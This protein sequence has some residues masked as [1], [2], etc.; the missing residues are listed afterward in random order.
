MNMIITYQVT[1]RVASRASASVGGLQVQ[2]VDKAVGG[3]AELAQATTDD[4]GVYTA[5]FSVDAVR[6]RGK[7]NPDLQ[8][9]VLADRTLLGASE[10]RYNA[11]P[12]ETLN[13]F[14][15]DAATSALRSEHEALILALGGQFKGRLRDLKESD[16]QQ[17]VT[18][19]ANKTGWDARVVAL[20]ALA[21]QFSAMTGGAAGG[22][23]AAAV[24][25]PADAAGAADAVNAAPIPPQFF[26]ALFRAGLP[27]NQDTL[28]RADAIT[29]EGIWKQAVTQGVIP[30]AS[31]EQIPSLVRR[32][33]DLS[34][35]RQL[36]GAALIGT[37]SLK[38]MLAVSGL[39]P[40]QQPKFAQIYAA[41]RRDPAAL[42]K[43]VAEA[44]GEPTATRL[45]I[46][47]KLGFLTVNN[48]PLMQKLHAEAGERGLSDVLQLA[49]MGLHRPSSWD[50]VLTADISIPKEIPGD[51]PEIKRA[52]YAA[53]L[54]AQVRLSYPTAAVAQMVSSGDLPLGDV[55]RATVD[56][57]YAFLT[58][59]EGKFEIGL[60]PVQQYIAQS[61]LL[62]PNETVRQVERLQR[63]YQI[64]PS[65]ESMMGLARRGVD[66]ALSV[67]RHGRETFV[68]GFAADLGGAHQAALT[69]ERS[70]QIHGSVLNIAL[71]YLHART[72]P[73][74]GVHSPAKNI[75][76]TPVNTGDVLA[77]ATLESLFGTMDFCACDHCR[78]ILSPA[79]YLVDLLQ[80]LGSDD[81]AWAAFIAAWKSPEGGHEGAPYPF[82]NQ[83]AFTQAGSPA[84]TEISPFAVLMSRRPDIENLALTCENTNTALPY[85]DVVNETLEYFVANSKPP[86]SLKDYPGHDTNGF[87]SEDL[88]ASP[89]FVI[90]SAYTTL[91]DE[92]FPAPLPFHRPLENLR[93][94]FSKFNV[95]LTLAMERFRKSDDLERGGNPYGWRDILME[96]VGLSRAEHEILT[97]S[98]AVPLW[99]MYGYPN[100]T[101]DADV[102]AD[103]SNGHQFA[104]RL[105]ISYNDLVCLLQARFINPNRD[106]I[107]KLERLGASFATLKGLKDGTIADVNFESQ[108]ASLAVPPDPKEYGA[109][110]I[111]A[112]V[113][114]NDNYNRIMGLITL[115]IPTSTWTASQAHALGDCVLPNAP[116]VGATLYYACTSAGK[117]AA[118]EPTWPMTP[119]STC[120]DGTVTWSCRDAATCQSFQDMAF[121]Y[122]DPARLAQNLSGADFVRM[123]RFIRLWKRLDWTIQQTDAAVCSLYRT[124]TSLPGAGDVGTVAKQDAGFLTL[125]PR[126]G[127]VMRAMDALNLNVNR[128]LLSLLACFAPIGISDSAQWVRDS[129]GGL[130]LLI[131]P[132]LYR[133][134]FLNPTLLEQDTVFADNGYGEFLTDGSKLPDHAEAL[135]SAFNLTADEYDRIISDLGYGAGTIMSIPTISAIFRR[136]W[137][138]RNLKVSVRELLLLMQFTRLD[139]F[140]AP[141]PAAPALMRLI[142]LVQAMKD[143]SFK[144]AAALYL[145]WNQDIS[146]K[147]APAAAQVAELGR[148]LRDDF[149][150]ID[151]Q[152]ATKEDPNGDVA[153]ARMTLV[154]GQETSDTFFGLLDGTT[155]VDVAYTHSAPAL[156]PA[157]S[158]ADPAIAYDD[159]RHRLSH[160]G[161][162][163]AAQQAALKGVVGVTA[164]FQKAVDGLFARSEE[165]KGLFFTAHHEL[166][167]PY[168]A[169]LTAAPADRHTAFLSAFDPELA[170]RRKRQQAVQRLSA[171]TGVDLVFTQAMLDPPAAPYPLHMGGDQTRPALDDVLA[172]ETPGLFA[173]FFFADTATGAVDQ[174]IAASAN[175]DYAS[176]GANPFPNPGN[177]VSGI[178]SGRV[179]TAD[180]GYY[181]FIIEADP[182]ATVTLKLGGQVQPLTQNGNVRRNT[183]P[184]ELTAHT[185]NDIEL[186]VEKVKD[187]M[188]LQW[189]TPKRS[190]E[191]IPSRYLYPPS[192]VAR[193]ANAYV[194]FLKA[195]SLA[196]GMGLTAG[197][198]SFFA[199]SIDYQIAADGWLNALSVSDDPQAATAE[200]LL[201]PF[202]A[203]LDFAR[204]KSDISPA[205]ESLLAAL[206]DPVLATHNADS[207]LFDMTGWDRTSLNDVLA[208]FG[209]NVQ[210]LA[211]FALFRRAYDAL[212]LAQRMGIPAG[213]LTAAVTNEPEPDMVR[214]L[215]S[216]LR[217]RYDAASW[218][219]VVKPV[220]DEMRSLQ[221]DA[222]VAYILHQMHAHPDSAHIDTPDKLFEFF[223]MDVQMEPVMQTS[224]IRHALSSVQL[225]IE[226][227]LM[228]LEPRVSPTAINAGQWLWMKRYRVWEANRK[229][230]LFPE[231][232]LEPE[233]R[234]DQSPFFKE[235]MSELL[236][237][238]ITEERA[239]TALLNYLAKLDEVAKLE[240]CGIYYIAADQVSRTGEV[241]HVVARTAGAHRKYYYRRR[242]YGYWTPWEQVKL[243]IEDNPIIPVVWNSR[244][245]L[246]WLRITKAM[247]DLDQQTASTNDS[248]EKKFPEMTP[249]DAKSAAKTDAQKNT[250]VKV[251]A[252]LCWSEF[253]NGK[254]QA[255]KTSDIDSPVMLGTC[256]ATG[257]DRSILRLRSDEQ[258]S[259]KLRISIYSDQ[260][261]GSFLLFNTHSLPMP[262]SLA[263]S[264]FPTYGT[265]RSF[266]TTDPIFKINYDKREAPDLPDNPITRDVLTDMID[267]RVVEPNHYL[268][269]PWSAPFFFEDRR[270]IF[271]VTTQEQPVFIRDTNDF[272][273]AVA[274]GFDQVPRIPP[275]IVQAGPPLPPKRFWGDGGPVGPDNPGIVAPG[276]I[277]Q[278]VTQDAYIR[279][280]IATSAVVTYGGKQI[281]P[282]GA[283]AKNSDAGM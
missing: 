63:I 272:G 234:D 189:E 200:A 99:R 169:A 218:R 115:A 21:D 133:Q 168:D 276:P 86:L 217:A 121:R 28:F 280:G 195:A 108:L 253:Y 230:Y 130:Q 71:S 196:A 251:Q 54:A 57:V 87:A 53:Y 269:D 190:R 183:D 146:G 34:A 247:I 80:F 127:I 73:A 244:L 67:V 222:L 156:E 207:L 84:G 184:I 14:L 48:A 17:D 281:G 12:G 58:Q 174:T 65:D 31:A 120:T 126:L 264:R 187:A 193:F 162:M 171:V 236:Q 72:A 257:F 122:S 191:V 255:A 201:R 147:S 165:I 159:F 110:G 22:A 37:S 89:Q 75:D 79:A 118:A 223:L 150:G 94:Y 13:V 134:M 211:Q 45:R 2:I 197:E 27:A 180:T 131:V 92:R 135:R 42:W 245:F 132:S 256:P 23:G 29:V 246:F 111:T 271:Y 117:S 56:S 215:Q 206:E 40:A 266:E 209:G 232:W 153:R 158:A 11:S 273:V 102:I 85:I 36:T 104:Q 10:V 4:Q 59:N 96:E 103:L 194:R 44:F 69:Y 175:I 239:A 137:L 128:D 216:A 25:V 225:F 259:G 136:G 262:S 267:M 1:G 88:L 277:K 101:A 114:N 24:A 39:A 212:A 254:W 152:F 268:P 100:G 186:K 205:A 182:A 214:N 261:S 243:D 210:G 82:A 93:R 78:S 41:N 166:K 192:V 83:A 46:D 138:A 235:T 203:L 98:T 3:D 148:T 113:K 204:L 260:A 66:S 50:R 181:N 90:N 199:T 240:P 26:Y 47:G 143:R 157:I 231:N 219:D 141:E 9:R 7:T 248:S 208:W 105:N 151:V 202:E 185:L 64:T 198:L 279:Q 32:F 15:D 81:M 142:G 170:R 227:C 30:K 119:G 167:A 283:L 275:L 224:R 35:Q 220:N 49:Q 176:G 252:V 140:A 107:P 62:V 19:L 161:T 123:L 55:P 97:D 149:A 70:V 155:V 139:P 5:I 249:S 274:P 144:S 74:I 229:V 177:P 154:Y 173:Q 6:K 179:E 145:V 250:Q 233:L 8:A 38:D 172:M 228:N 241:A 60:Q 282:S 91:Y 116:Q 77:Y 109:A 242:E 213:A 106:L 258:Q 265:N 278:F 221:R 129:E 163:A 16:T 112:W 238:D 43:A 68:K 160:R 125:L 263:P 18:Y 52:N 178:W 188:S 51:T 237:G 124:D 20:A 226:R 270:N 61:K 95:P 164:D 33:Q 76:P